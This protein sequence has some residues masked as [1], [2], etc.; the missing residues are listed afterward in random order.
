MNLVVVNS[1]S[2]MGPKAWSLVVLIP[3]SEP[4]PNSNPSLN[5]VEAFTRTQEELTSL[6]NLWAF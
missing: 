2:P 1:S 5:R 3:I 4:N 6:R